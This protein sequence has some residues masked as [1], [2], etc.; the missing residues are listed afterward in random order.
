MEKFLKEIKIPFFTIFFLFVFVFLYSKFG[1][2]LPLFI[3]SIQTTKQSLFLV[4]GSATKITAPDTA[5]ISFG[6]TKTANTT[7]DAQNQTNTLVTKII[8]GLQN[9]G[10]ATKDI[11]T[12]EYNVS[13]QYN[14][15]NGSQTI[16]GYT[17]TQNMMITIKPL[18]KVNQ[19]T[20]VATTNGANIVNGVTFGFD[21]TTQKQ[22]QNDVR[23]MAIDDAKQKAQSLASAAGMRLGRIVDI[24]EDNQLPPR[25]IGFQALKAGIAQSEAAPTNI[26]PGENTITENVTLSYE[27]Y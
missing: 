9:I 3:N 10:I 17:V 16:T 8:N 5:F 23:Q 18:D 21:D 14:Y 19:A 25:P 27:T 20:D 1:P 11:K 4:Q 24:Q 12:T 15:N 2:P 26:T 22:L 6:V 7:A 13:P